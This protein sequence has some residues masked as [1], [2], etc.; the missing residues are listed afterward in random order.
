MPADLTIFVAKYLVFLDGLLALA[1]IAWLLARRP[2]ADAVRWAIAILL[3]LFLSFVFATIGAAVYS[4]PRPFSV[5]H[6]KPL[7]PHAADNGFPSDHALLAAAI[8]AA[9]LIIAPLW[10]APFVVLGVLVDWARVGAGIHHVS[11]VVGS[12]VFVAIATLIAVLV[13]P[14]I[15]RALTPYLP[16]SWTEEPVQ[17]TP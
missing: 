8:V 17:S 14:F 12:V 4:D 6:V 3:L 1:V 7:I 10:T 15:Y 11:D 9:V 13:T 16:A 2:R 5:D